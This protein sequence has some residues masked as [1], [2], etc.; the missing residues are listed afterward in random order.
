MQPDISSAD[1]LITRADYVC[2]HVNI[3]LQYVS[4]R[5]SAAVAHVHFTIKLGSRSVAWVVS[6]TQVSLSHSI[7][8]SEVLGHCIRVRHL[9]Q[10]KT[11]SRRQQKVDTQTMEDCDVIYFRSIRMSYGWCLLFSSCL[12]C[13]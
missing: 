1:Y 5:I 3:S 6:R 7:P 11:L 13:T 8:C 10:P 12:S 9:G 4:I 2:V